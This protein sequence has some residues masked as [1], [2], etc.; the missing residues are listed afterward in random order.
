MRDGG[1]PCVTAATT[2]MA[3]SVLAEIG[4]LL[5]NL[6]ETGSTGSVD[7]RSL[8]LTD[9]DRA[10]LEELLG[11]GE[12]S[13][14]LDIA[15]RSTV[16]ETSFSGVW[17]IRHLGAGDR[18]AAEEIAVCPVPEIL[19]SHPADIDAAARRIRHTLNESNPGQAEAS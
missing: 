3:H 7:L 5:E 4:R 12:V 13:A 11:P 10:Q 16:R 15:G 2:G 6:A 19:L 14:E 8:P 18:I 9:A 17:W 1:A